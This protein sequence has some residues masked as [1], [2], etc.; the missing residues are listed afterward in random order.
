MRNTFSKACKI[1]GLNK[2]KNQAGKMGVPNE[3]EAITLPEQDPPRLK[4]E[5][6]HRMNR[7]DGQKMGVPQML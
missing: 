2:S 7:E 4:G 6:T 1:S 5:D 3:Q